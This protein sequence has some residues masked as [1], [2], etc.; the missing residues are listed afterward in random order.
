MSKRQW[1]M[2]SVIGEDILSSLSSLLPYYT[3][4][5]ETDLIQLPNDALHD[6]A[7][8][9]LMNFFTTIIVKLSLNC[10]GATFYQLSL[11]YH[12]IKM[13]DL[14]VYLD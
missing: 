1:L 8:I 10:R 13:V 14:E 9:G 6:L 4:S 5:N 2:F 12:L 11:A 3:S 7:N